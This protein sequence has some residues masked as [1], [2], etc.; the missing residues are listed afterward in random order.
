[1]SEYNK[2][3]KPSTEKRQLYNISYKMNKLLKQ[4]EEIKSKSPT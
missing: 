2:K 3:Y 1:M 4:L